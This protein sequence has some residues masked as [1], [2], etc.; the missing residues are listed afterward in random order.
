MKKILMSLLLL[1]F[2]LVLAQQTV[3]APPPPDNAAFV[4]VIN[5]SPSTASLNTSIGDASFDTLEYG[6]I[7]A[8]KVVLAG[9]Y[10]LTAAGL[11]GSV[12][13]EAGNYYSVVLSNDVSVMKDPQNTNL[14]KT[15]LVLYNVSDSGAVAMKT[16]DG[17]T[18]VIE[19][20][21]ASS[22][23]SILVNPIQVDLAAFEGTTSINSFAGL[24][25]Q[26]G[27]VYSMVV[28]GSADSLTANWVRNEVL[29]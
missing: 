21:D 1:S 28:M 20:V 6:G 10:D 7:S 16:A 9:S 24:S 3:Y 25:L 26:S 17:S 2:G 23:N 12:S 11:S 8:Y 4:R 14:A 27:A 29:Q 5:A 22:M 13:V 19:G 15:M 18:A